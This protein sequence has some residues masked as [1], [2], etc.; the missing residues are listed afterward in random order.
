LLSS[1]ASLSEFIVIAKSAAFAS[2]Y[3][4]LVAL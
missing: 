1:S 3:A 2:M 4:F